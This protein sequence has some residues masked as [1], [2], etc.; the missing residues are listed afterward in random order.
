[1]TDNQ[2][3]VFQLR[4]L[5]HELLH[6]LD[7]GDVARV[8]AGDQ[9]ADERKSGQDTGHGEAREGGGRGRECA[10]AHWIEHRSGGQG[11]G[12]QYLFGPL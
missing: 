10:R 12:R 7:F 2:V 11:C 1:M 8:T 5:I 6:A 4:G 9:D 3:R